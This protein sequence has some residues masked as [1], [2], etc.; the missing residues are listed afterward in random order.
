MAAQILDGIDIVEGSDPRDPPAL[1]VPQ[2]VGQGMA[3]RPSRAR[4]RRGRAAGTHA[5]QP[6]ATI[7]RRS[8][9]RIG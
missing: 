6:I 5:D 7:G 3:G 4:E 1:K 2:R 9:H 8:E